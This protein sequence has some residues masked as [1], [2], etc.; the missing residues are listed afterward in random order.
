MTL[1]LFLCNT[2]FM[3]YITENILSDIEDFLLEKYNSP[4]VEGTLLFQTISRND[5][6][7]SS[8]QELIETPAETFQDKLFN[9]IKTK[10]LDEVEIYKRANISR[11]LFSK[12]R[13]EKN[14]HPAK[15]TIFSLAI[16]MKLNIDETS[17]LLDIAG[18]TFTSA[19]KT[20]LIIQYFL[21]HNNHNIFAINE[22]LYKYELEI[23]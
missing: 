15:N 3:K 10:N 17:E 7:K 6:E 1:E 14:Y 16:G 23:L 5:L 4:T 9:M 13:S 18:Y 20:D 11:Q 8:L 21:H 12:I 2:K 22:V 19:S